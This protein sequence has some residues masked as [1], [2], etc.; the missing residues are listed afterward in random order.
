M[1]N[2]RS[3][4][5]G[6]CVPLLIVVCMV[7]A[8]SCGDIMDRLTGTYSGPQPSTDPLQDEIVVVRSVHPALA[9]TWIVAE[10]IRFAEARDP[11]NVNR[12]V[13]ITADASSQAEVNALALQAGDTL[14]VSTRFVTITETA[15][16]H[17]V[18]N[19]PGHNAVEYPVSGHN[20]T[21]ARRH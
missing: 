17:G 6:R 18:P 14:V 13:L 1:I 2:A 19:W 16:S 4:R 11:H 7:G 10:R 3:I 15:G 9:G 21:S 5:L 20:F 8:A 12:V